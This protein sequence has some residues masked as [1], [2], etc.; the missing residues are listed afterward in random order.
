MCLYDHK[1]VP[2]VTV[3]LHVMHSGRQGN[4]CGR[5][6]NVP[7]AAMPPREMGE[8]PGYRA[9][10]WENHVAVTFFIKLDSR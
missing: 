8:S 6:R 5:Q 2:S 10:V 4:I 9:G 7:M 1:Y 3:L